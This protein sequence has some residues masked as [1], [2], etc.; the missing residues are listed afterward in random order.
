MEEA[1]KFWEGYNLNLKRVFIAPNTTE[2]LPIDIIPE[3][4]KDILFVGTL[5]KGKG[6]DKLLSSVKKVVDKGYSSI[7]LSIVGDGE[8]RNDLENYVIENELTNNVTFTG[9]IFEESVL[10]LYFSQALLCVSPT[11]GGL[12]CPKSMGYGVPFVTKKGAITGGEIYHMTSGVNG[13]MY[14]DDDD[15]TAIIED[16]CVNPYKYVR[17]GLLAKEY[18]DNNATIKHMAQ[19]AINALTF[20]LNK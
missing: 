3:K 10:S 7:H 17:M 12:S 6:I 1:K 9:G 20:V 2:V 18:Y 16:A 19:G 15:L 4:K 13:L 5:Y 8:C 14:D 11:Q